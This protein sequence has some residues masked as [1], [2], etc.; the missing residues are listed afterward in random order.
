MFDAIENAIIKGAATKTE[1]QQSIALLRELMDAGHNIVASWERGDLAGAVNR[2]ECAMDE[3][4][5]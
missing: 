1:A 4:E 5:S 3:I 2:L